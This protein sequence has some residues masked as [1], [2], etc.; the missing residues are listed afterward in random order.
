MIYLLIKRYFLFEQYYS[1]YMSLYLIFQMWKVKY[2]NSINSNP[3]QL[4]FV[5]L[6]T[7]SSSKNCLNVLYF[8][9]VY[10]ITLKNK[11]DKIIK[12]LCNILLHIIYNMSTWLCN[13][14][15][16][17]LQTSHH[18]SA[19]HWDSFELLYQFFSFQ[20]ISSKV[21]FKIL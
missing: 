15:K 2:C 20:K 8:F 21:L 9:T 5:S 19:N 6:D 11:I 18:N 14:V 7:Y 17:W 16:I 10:Y 1:I 12:I 4:I 13:Y 3:I